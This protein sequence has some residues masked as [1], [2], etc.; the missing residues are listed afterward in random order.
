MDENGATRPSFGFLDLMVLVAE[1]WLALVLTPL[2]FAALAFA[3]VSAGPHRYESY[4]DIDAPPEAVSV[5]ATRNYLDTVFADPVVVA[6]YGEQLPD[7]QARGVATIGVEVLGSGNSAR[8]SAQD[9]DPA[10]SAALIGA[11]VSHLPQDVYPVPDADLRRQDQLAVETKAL[12]RYERALEQ[13]EATL[14][15]APTEGKGATDV[16]QAVDYAAAVAL[17]VADIRASELTIETLGSQLT[18]AA[19]P[20]PLVVTRNIA[21]PVTNAVTFAAFLG[22][23]LVLAIQ[24]SRTSLRHLRSDP[25]T[26]VKLRRIRRGFGRLGGGHGS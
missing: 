16:P 8:I 17:V 7:L 2:A 10:K 25:Q 11:I 21:L 13:L 15:P 18:A 4:A 12:A 1:S 19:P 14:A 23:V 3:V 22:L 20:P 9:A 24:A 5:V 26:T 6:A